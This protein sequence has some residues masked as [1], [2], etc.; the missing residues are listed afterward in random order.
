MC[1]SFTGIRFEIPK[2]VLLES[3]PFT[4]ENDMMTPTFKIKRHPL[5]QKYREQIT[6]MYKEIHQKDSKL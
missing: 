1:H 6:A 4:V 2:A 5:I 3:D